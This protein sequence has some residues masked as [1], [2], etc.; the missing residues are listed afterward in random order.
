M[1]TLTTYVPITPGYSYPVAAGKI[2]YISSSYPAS[3]LPITTSGSYAYFNIT[4]SG[5]PLGIYHCLIQSV[6]TPGS[7][8]LKLSLNIGFG[9]S[10]LTLIGSGNN[11]NS[12]NASGTTDP[13]Y[14]TTPAFITVTNV[15]TSFITVQAYS[16]NGNSTVTICNLYAMCVA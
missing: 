3:G 16:Q 9:V 6:M 1:F 10:G 4:T 15:S 14:S 11:V 2:G 5:L 8:S 13:W 7:G 12:Y